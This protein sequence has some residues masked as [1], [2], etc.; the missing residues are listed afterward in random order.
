MGKKKRNQKQKQKR[1]NEHQRYVE[2][3]R[4]SNAAGTHGSNRYSRKEKY[5]ADYRS[6]D[7]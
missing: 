2:E 1:S 5:R 3:L 4:R 7:D 6:E